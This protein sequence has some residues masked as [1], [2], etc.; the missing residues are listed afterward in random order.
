MLLVWEPCAEDVVLTTL[1]SGAGP[2]AERIEVARLPIER[3]GLL[4]DCIEATRNASE[5]ISMRAI[6]LKRSSASAL[7]HATRAV[8]DELPE[9]VRSLLGAADAIYYSPSNQSAL[10]EFPLEALHDGERFLGISKAITRVPSL[11]HL[12]DL[13]AENRYGQAPP[14]RAV[15]VRAKDPQRAENDDTVKQQAGLIASAIEELSLDLEVL[16]EPSVDEFGEAVDAPA[17]LMH[18][19]GHG[20]ADEGGEVLVLSETEHVPIARV[21]SSAEVRAPFAS[22]SACEVGRG[23]QMS[24]GAQRGLAATFLDAGAP[25]ILAPAY[26]IPSHFLGLFAAVF[27]QQCAT[28]PAA[29][30]L[31]QTRKLLQAQHYHPACW[32]TVALFG[33][34]YACLTAVAAAARPERPASWKSLLFQHVVTQ[35]PSRRRRCLE[36]LEAD[37]RLDAE[38]R[39]RIARWLREGDVDPGDAAALLDRLDGQDAEAA[40]LLRILWTVQDVEGVG[41]DSPQDAQEAARARLDRCLHVATALQDCY[42]AICVIEALRGVGVRMDALGS[43]RQLLDH[44]QVLLDRLSI[45]SAA[46][47]RIATPLAELREKMSTMTFK[48]IGTAG[49]TTTTTWSRPT[50]AIPVRCGASRC[51]CSRARGTPRR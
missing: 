10:D 41:T 7:E 40:A 32:A 51:R 35:E 50:R 4:L 22:F 16:D 15:L 30:A 48:N 19:V 27:Y 14:S 11:E 12:S 20:F 45:D 28:L 34:P 44:E 43:Y 1:A 18:F 49:A 29:L 17:T 24:S 37:P 38:D 23:R 3:A 9:S 47:E 46:L 13:L 33:D 5:Q 26:R 39:S 25:A 21:L 6:G 36:A 2:L 42:A 31:M 8:W